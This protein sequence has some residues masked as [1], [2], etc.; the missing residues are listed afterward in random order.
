[1][2]DAAR[3]A[4]PAPVLE[5]S[6]L[7][8]RFSLHARGIGLNVLHGVHLAVHA[9]QVTVL[10]GPSGA[11]KSSILK[12]IYRTYL[13]TAG[14][15]NY[16]TGAGEMVDLA[17]ADD[18]TILHLRRWEIGYVAQFLH[19][20]PRQPA[21]DVVARPLVERGMNREQAR[22]GARKILAHLRIP[23]ALTNLPPATFSGGEKQRVNLARGFLTR[24]RL[25]LL[26][27]PTA[28]LD[29]ESQERVIELILQAKAEGA[30]ILAIFHDRSLID[31]LA[32]ARVEVVPDVRVEP[33]GGD[34]GA[35]RCDRP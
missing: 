29:Q 16:R 3:P 26:D 22:A 21:L 31:R 7:C 11:G 35:C 1:M 17:K 6:G 32:D 13:P 5:A 15:L 2:V 33:L 27:E 4:M 9:G 30:A 23:E 20:L 14:S 34:E 12:A 25:L 18:H 10:T 24:P 19:C 8:K 28:S